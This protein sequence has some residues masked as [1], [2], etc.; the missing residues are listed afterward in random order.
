VTLKL[1][2][3]ASFRLNARVVT[4]GEIIT[5]FPVKTTAAANPPPPPTNDKHKHSPMTPSRLIGTVGSG[6]AELNLFTFSGTVH[7]KKQ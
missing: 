6:D 1:P 2:Q 4:G 3:N 7:L 5:D